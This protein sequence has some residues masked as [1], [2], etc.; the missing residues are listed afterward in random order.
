MCDFLEGRGGEENQEMGG[1]TEDGR[2]SATDCRSGIIF[3]TRRLLA[4][5]FNLEPQGQLLLTSAVSYRC[6][7]LRSVYL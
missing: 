4:R 1:R 6:V 2:N 5:S 7:L 3:T